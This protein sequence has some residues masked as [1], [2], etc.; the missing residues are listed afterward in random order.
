MSEFKH[1]KLDWDEQG[2]PLSNQFDD[3]YFSRESGLAETQY[4]FLQ[5]NHLP[6]RFTALAPC[7]R[8]V[9]GETGFGT[10]LNFLATWRLF[11]TL[12]PSNSQLHFISVERYPLTA[13]DLT[14]ALS[15]WPELAS[16]SEQLLP[17]Y[18]AIQEGFQHLSFANGHITLSLL[19][20]DAQSMLEQLDAQVDA[21]FLDGFSPAKNP[22]MWNEQ[23]FAQ[24][25]RLS[26]PNT[27]LATFTSAG[28]VRRGLNEQGFAMQR[29]KGFGQKREMLVGTYQKPASY[30]NLPWFVRPTHAFKQRKAVILGAGI[31]GCATAYSL[32]N[33]GWHV[34][35]LEQREAVAQEASGNQQGIMYLKLSAHGTQLTQLIMSGFGYT[36]RLLASLGDSVAWQGC[37]LLQLPHTEKEAFRLKE[38]TTSFPKSLL[39]SVNKEQ[40]STLAGIPI[41]HEGVFFPDSGWLNPASLCRTL[42][43]H[44]NIQLRLNCPITDI[45]YEHEQWQL[46]N[47]QAL[48]TQAP[49]L[50]LCN[51]T[52]VKNFNQTAHLLVKNV[53]G[54]TTTA[55]ATMAS[56][57]LKT[58][59]SAE[60]YCAPAWQGQHTFGASFNFRPNGQ[61]VTAEEQQSNL[62]LLEAISTEFKQSLA[63]DSSQLGGH[64]AYRSTT[65]DYLPLA[66][67]IADAQAFAKVYA[68]L[69]RNARKV[70]EGECPWHV[71]LYTN[72]AQGSR[73]MITAPLMAELVAAYINNEPLPID[74]ELAN[75][76]HPNRFLVKQLMRNER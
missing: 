44:P 57:A 7:Q 54:Q 28:F 6:Q 55:P 50:V 63:I 70:P 53:G 17:Q 18:L 24:L 3:I 42:L 32:A 43:N 19:I 41:E 56:R 12:A 45:A 2:Q 16:Y 22:Q 68:R 67:P 74:K 11:E 69:R 39:Y 35:V 65:P 52:N 14:K 61:E 29:I 34:E 21:W 27:S 37:G 25:A 59:I 48:I 66:G 62:A 46:F 49:V 58:V 64:A 5:Q 8:F 20:G 13:T 72:S 10:G 47:Q 71:G 33:R 31:S 60:G 1:A 75:A 9:I 15:L 23:L 40:A 26:S 38:L 4:V 30:Q 51:A 73:G 36:R 76:C